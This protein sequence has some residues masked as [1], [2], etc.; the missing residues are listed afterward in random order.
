MKHIHFLQKFQPVHKDRDFYFYRQ[1]FQVLVDY[2]SNN[3][4]LIYSD[5]DFLLHK[6]LIDKF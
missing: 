4:L 2:G 5:T 6:K 3:Q 1:L